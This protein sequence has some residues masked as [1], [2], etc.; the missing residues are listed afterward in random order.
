MINKAV[1]YGAFKTYGELPY[2][3]RKQ[4]KQLELTNKVWQSTT[5]AVD[6]TKPLDNFNNGKTVYKQTHVENTN[7]A[8]YHP[9][10]V[11]KG[12]ARTLNFDKSGAIKAYDR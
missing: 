9:E 12:G 1:G 6:Q 5:R 11:P 4:G 3:T 7:P 8:D 10:H 2:P